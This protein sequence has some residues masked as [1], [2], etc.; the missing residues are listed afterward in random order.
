MTADSS[1][2]QRLG[3]A[4]RLLGGLSE[5]GPFAAHTDLL[6]ALLR[7]ACALMPV[8]GIPGVADSHAGGLP[9]L[10]EGTG[11]PMHQRDDGYVEPMT[12]VGQVRLDELDPLWWDG[13]RTGLL[14]FFYAQGNHRHSEDSEVARVLHVPLDGLRLCERPVDDRPPDQ[15]HPC[16]PLT[17]FPAKAWTTAWYFDLPDPLSAALRPLDLLGGADDGVDEQEDFDDAEAFD[18]ED[19]FDDEIEFGEVDEFALVD[20]FYEFSSEFLEQQDLPTT[21]VEACDAFD[22]GGATLL[23]WPAVDQFDVLEQN[24]E[25]DARNAEQERWQDWMVLLC[26]G[27]DAATLMFTL[28]ITDLARG[29]FTAVVAT[30]F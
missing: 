10:P 29:D 22:I 30:S 18:D 11:W 24:A 7:P 8:S 28:P 15:C 21:E 1:R 12:F 14:S 6:A 25:L 17:P 16:H 5:G 13:P 2:A 4:Q 23:G 27:V 9:G 20:K 19:D 3:R 26:T